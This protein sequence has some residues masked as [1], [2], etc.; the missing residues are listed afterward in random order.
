MLFLYCC[1][2]LPL[3]TLAFR[4]FSTTVRSIMVFR[5]I[6]S[7]RVWQSERL[8]VVSGRGHRT[9]DHG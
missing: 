6:A 8:T 4:G 7:I 1:Y 9:P 2:F 3:H 5:M